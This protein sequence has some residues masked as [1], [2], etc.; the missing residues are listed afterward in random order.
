MARIETGHSGDFVAQLSRVIRTL[1]PTGNCTADRV[2]ELFSKHRRTMHRLLSSRGTTF[3]R[4]MDAM[5]RQI[6]EQMLEQSDMKLTQLADMLGY[7][8]VSSFNHAFRRWAGMSPSDWR[9]M[10]NI[11]TVR[12]R[13]D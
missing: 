10:R 2:A 5:R 4:T 7:S 3:E 1:L 6:A 12:Q 13:L 9:S 11:I 8:E